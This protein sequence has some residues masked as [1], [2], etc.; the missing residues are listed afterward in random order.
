MW[1]C[2]V[3]LILC[4]YKGSKTGENKEG[5]GGVGVGV[6][7]FWVC[8]LPF[9]RVRAYESERER[10]RV[11]VGV[12]VREGEGESGSRRVCEREREKEWEREEM[13]LVE[14]IHDVHC[15]LI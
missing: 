11:E 15:S 9:R 5:L 3:K 14:W 1:V 6:S 12:Y 4:R 10:E 8:F 13:G 2:S 7:V